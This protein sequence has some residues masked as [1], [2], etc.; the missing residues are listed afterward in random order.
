MGGGRESNCS[1]LEAISMCEEITDRKMNYSYSDENRIGD[2]IW[3]ISDLS[4]FKTRYP[5]WT[6]RH[7]VPDILSEIY[8]TNKDKWLY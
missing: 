5:S 1:M 8:E 7:T 4:R 6:I 3:Y 2:H